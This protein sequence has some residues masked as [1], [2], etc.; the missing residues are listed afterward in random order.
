[1]IAVLLDAR[2]KK[3]EKVNKGS[4]IKTRTSYSDRILTK[5]YHINTIVIGK[6]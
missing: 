2:Q 3:R 4:I 6:L 1:M 5:S